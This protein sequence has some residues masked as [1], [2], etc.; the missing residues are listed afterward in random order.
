MASRTYILGTRSSPLA[1]WQAQFVQWL[2]EEQWPDDHFTVLAIKTTGD[3]QSLSISK[4]GGKG[5]FIKELE[6][7]LIS[8]KVD[9]CVHSMKDFPVNPAGGCSLAAV[10]ERGEVRDVL[11]S[12]DKKTL[13]EFTSGMKIGTSSLRRKAILGSQKIGA[14]VVDIR[15]NIDTRIAKMKKGEVDGLILAAAGVLRLGL[16]NEISE[17][18]E[19]K[20][21]VPAPGQGAIA[22]ECR[23]EDDDLRLK[24]RRIH[25]DES[26]QAVAAERAFLRALGGN[27][28]LPLG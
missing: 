7:A 23:S 14:E 20:I 21:F 19:P 25:H 5:L 10:V 28:A 26:G 3:D 22:V 24:L 15:G 1:M 11:L 8:H 2:L 9:F 6:E 16:E 17:Y 27:C 18:F 12:R 4:E 13:K